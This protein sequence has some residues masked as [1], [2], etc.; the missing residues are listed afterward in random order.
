MIKQ[1]SIFRNFVPFTWKKHWFFLPTPLLA[2]IET[3]IYPLIGLLFIILADLFTALIAHFYTESKKRKLKF[4][5]FRHGI[6]SGGL[7][8]TI[9]KSYQYGMAGIVVFIIEIWGFGGQVEF[10]VPLVQLDA[11][12]TKFILWAFFMIELKS[13][14]EN[15]SKVSGKSAIESIINIFTYFRKVFSRIKGDIKELAVKKKDD[16]PKY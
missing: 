5:D 3:V 8:Q 12:L 15:L 4:A 1:Y 7:R 16:S 14:D 9:K 13:I 2:G 10:T 6:V 11:T